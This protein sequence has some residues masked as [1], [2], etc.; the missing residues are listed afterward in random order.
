MYLSKLQEIEP[1]E[2]WSK[3]DMPQSCQII[4][5]RDPL[6]YDGERITG[7]FLVPLSDL[8]SASTVFDRERPLFLLCR[9]GVRAQRAAKRL[10]S[11]GFKDVFVIKGGLKGWIASGLP[12]RRS[13]ASHWS[14]E[15]QV[16]FTAG[17]LVLT[18]IVLACLVNANYILLT[19]VVAL[20]MI[21]SA[22]TNSCTMGVLLGMLP[23]NQESN[24]PN[25]RAA[26]RGERCV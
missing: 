23:W 15:R 10:A 6:E 8:D 24:P 20:G 21:V 18:G 14:I 3:M 7:S 4:D 19:A 22:V 1:L 13:T 11:L 9:S 16:R 25:E 17:V 26:N 2:V 12:V 5:V